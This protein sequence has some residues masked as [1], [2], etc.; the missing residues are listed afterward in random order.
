MFRI[1]EVLSFVD[2]GAGGLELHDVSGILK[3]VGQGSLIDF[4]EDAGTSD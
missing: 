2:D 4:L 1:A 3:F